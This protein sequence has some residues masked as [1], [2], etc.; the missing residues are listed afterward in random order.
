MLVG[1]LTSIA[2][3]QE[4]HLVVITGHAFQSLRHARERERRR[5]AVEMTDA[6]GATVR[7][8]TQVDA[9]FDGPGDYEHQTPEVTR[10]V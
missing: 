7:I 4:F 9:L 2:W 10:T 6:K 3:T 8:T 1:D 5:N